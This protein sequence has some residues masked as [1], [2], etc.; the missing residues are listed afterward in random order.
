[1]KKASCLVGSHPHLLHDPRSAHIAAYRVESD[2]GLRVPYL[3]FEECIDESGHH[4][5]KRSAP[6]V[7]ISMPQS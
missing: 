2:T 5:L 1:M 6:W 3:G 7:K 4:L